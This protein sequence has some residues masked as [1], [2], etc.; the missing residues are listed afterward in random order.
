MVYIFLL[1]AEE[2]GTNRVER[3]ATQLVLALH[4]LEHINLQAAINNGI[5]RDAL[6]ERLRREVSLFCLCL[7]TC[8]V[9]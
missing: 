2:L 7:G 9:T 3:V 1:L 5:L 8:V 6:A 4:V